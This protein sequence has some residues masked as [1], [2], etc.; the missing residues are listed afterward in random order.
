[1]KKL[2]LVGVAA[3]AAIAFVA[4]NRSSNIPSMMSENIEALTSRDPKANTSIFIYPYNSESSVKRKIIVWRKI[5]NN[6]QY[7]FI[8]GEP[9]SDYEMVNW[10]G[11]CNY[12]Y[13]SCSANWN[14]CYPY[15]NGP[16]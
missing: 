16:Q 9:E 10:G 13:P 8:P 6:S 14:Y 15:S 3:V 12:N 1:M 5:N 4:F 11:G 2:F 7:Y